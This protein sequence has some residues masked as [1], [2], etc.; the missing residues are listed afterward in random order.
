MR[1]IS[2]YALLSA[3]SISLLGSQLT[4]VALPWFVLQ[5]TGSAART[6]LTGFSVALPYFLVGIFGGA[7]VDR[8]GYRNTSVL[9]DV[10]S[11]CAIGAVPILY[12]TVGIAF[13]QLLVLVFFGSFLSIPGL[14]AR[15]SL[16]PEVATASGVRLERVNAAYEGIWPA[17]TLLGPPLAGLLIVWLGASNVLFI[18]AATFAASALL[19]LVG[20]QAGRKSVAT[21]HGRYFDE[22]L[23]GIRFLRQERL[24]LAMA[25]SLTASNFLMGPLF[26]VVLPVY[27]RNVF[28]S[29]KDLGFML[30][31]FGAG[32]V[33]G[34]LLYGL[35]GDR[36][37]RRPI[38]IAGF[39]AVALP[40]WVLAG[41]LG[42]SVVLVAMALCGLGD[43]PLTPLTVTIR[44]ERTPSRL[45]GRV[46]S[47]FSA[48]STMAVPLGL[49]ATGILIGAE[50]LGA[51]L[52]VLGSLS[53]LLA[54]ATLIVPVF[55]SLGP[56]PDRPQ[57]TELSES[58]ASPS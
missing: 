50:G 42:I 30:S 49:A 34:S 51:S 39:V 31:A 29:A 24:L 23:E 28:N 18:D 37:P 58:E 1:R 3:N 13:W 19:V 46:F 41:K 38:W 53:L 25:A 17:A 36:L 43:G 16:L 33:G 15:R 56:V 44:H 2:L 47:S 27:A 10:V 9:A 8:F 32:Q 6:G 57:V 11:G 40:F 4:V 12:H 55:R 54:S 21:T 35:A 20:V 45:R 26:G 48:V 52:L 5:T 22:L 7:L 14:S